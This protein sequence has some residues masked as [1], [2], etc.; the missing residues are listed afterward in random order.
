MN[1]LSARLLLLIGALLVEKAALAQDLAEVFD[2]G[3]IPW[4]ESEGA[5][6]E[7]GENE[8]DEEEIETDR[9]SFTPATTTVRRGRM[10]FESS[11]SFI[12]N[13]ETA[14][15]HSFPEII[16]RY[17]LTDRVELRLG[18]NYEIGGGGEVSNGD[19]GGAEEDEVA[20]SERES[21]ALY[22]FKFAITE[23]RGWIPQSAGI[24]QATTPT[25]GP[26]T[27]TE[28]S[29]GYVF[30]WTLFDDWKFDSA[31]RYRPTGTEK[32][33]FNEWAPSVVLKVP[34][35]DKWTA[36]AE[37]FGIFTE[38]KTDG[39]NRQYI[40][41]GIH[42]LVTPDCEIGVRVGWGLNHDAANF[43][44]NVGLGYQF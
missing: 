34:V 11:Y 43:F 41:P 2:D 8:N 31:L 22:G 37:Y 17:G 40:S 15:N 10:I 1:R 42:Y 32:D 30:G 3:E 14:G 7:E 24:I 27:N 38:G 35:A 4:L 26:E 19:S 39:S 23:Q 20:G 29:L 25:S 12:E 33:R 16:T 6:R 36:H 5:E 28:P 9:D 44:S 21:Q 18:W 13:R